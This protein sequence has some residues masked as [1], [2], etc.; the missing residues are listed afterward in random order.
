MKNMKK[1]L[2]LALLA[3]TLISV[4]LPALALSGGYTAASQYLSTSTLRQGNLSNNPT[5]VRNLQLML[6]ALG[7]NPGP[8]D[9]IYGPLTYEAV[10]AFQRDYGLTPRDGICGRDTKTKIWEVLWSL[11]SGCVP[12]W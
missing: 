11:P 3:V 9:G 5:A 1:V 12:V 4:A 7:Y 2:A 6:Q 8:I 10:W